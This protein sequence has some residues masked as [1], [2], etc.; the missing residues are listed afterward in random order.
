MTIELAGDGADA[1]FVVDARGTRRTIAI[2]GAWHSAH[3]A[4]VVA[5][6]GAAEAALRIVAAGRADRSAASELVVI[7][8]ASR[9]RAEEQQYEDR[10]ELLHLGKSSPPII[11]EDPSARASSAS[12]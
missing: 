9:H 7:V 10:A 8:T 3:A 12:P 4:W 11:D 1:A 5:A 2:V 6:F